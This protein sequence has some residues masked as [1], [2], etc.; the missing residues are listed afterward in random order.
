MGTLGSA[1]ALRDGGPGAAAGSFVP[2]I[3]SI[4]DYHR[5]CAH[6]R[7]GGRILTQCQQSQLDSRSV[8]AMTV[9]A[10]R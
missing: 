3:A 4:H 1:S 2:V 7:S 8:A 6:R 9:S 10:I 5:L